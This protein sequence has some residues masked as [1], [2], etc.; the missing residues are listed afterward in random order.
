MP[1]T[2][3]IFLVTEIHRSFSTPYDPSTAK[4]DFLASNSIKT[5]SKTAKDYTETSNR[6]IFQGFHHANAEGELVF[7]QYVKR[8]RV[9]DTI[10]HRGR[11]GTVVLVAFVQDGREIFEVQ[12]VKTEWNSGKEIVAEGTDTAH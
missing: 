2:K 5:K 12:V 1:D 6:R 9:F 4:E 3:P 8:H 11:D 10:R 7:D